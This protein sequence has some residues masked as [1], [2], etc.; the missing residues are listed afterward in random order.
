[1]D[2]VNIN[3]FPINRYRALFHFAHPSTMHEGFLFS[4]IN[5][6]I[7]VDIP[8]NVMSYQSILCFIHSIALRN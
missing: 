5:N 4:Y 7:N 6:I 1:M 8:L 2:F 3:I